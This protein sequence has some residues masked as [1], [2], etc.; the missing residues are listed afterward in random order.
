M[1]A[2]PNALGEHEIPLST[3][4]LLFLL[5]PPGDAADLFDAED[6]MLDM[7]QYLAENRYGF[8]RCPGDNRAGHRLWWRTIWPV[9]HGKGSRE[10]GQFIPPPLTAL[11]GPPRRMAPGLLAA[12]IVTLAA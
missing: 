11:A 3:L 2:R 9:L 6:G 5:C 12:V 10:G 8:C 4:A 1:S 7:S